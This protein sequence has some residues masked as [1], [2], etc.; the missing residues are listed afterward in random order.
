MKFIGTKLSIEYVAAID[1]WRHAQG[2]HQLTRGEALEYFV[3]KG[4]GLNLPDFDARRRPVTR[5]EREERSE[6]YCQLYAELKSYAAVAREVGL[7][8]STVT[9]V[10][11]RHIRLSRSSVA[12]AGQFK[13]YNS[14][15]DVKT[16]DF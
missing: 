15:K 10:I 16:Y 7:S 4:L 3:A 8:V 5:A 14:G 13:P 1:E 12:E 9:R 2:D 11:N 6:L